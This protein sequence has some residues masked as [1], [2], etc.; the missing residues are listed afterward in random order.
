MNVLCEWAVSIQRTG[1][2]RALVVAKLL[3]R[4]QVEVS[5]RMPP[6]IDQS[7]KSVAGLFHTHLNAQDMCILIFDVLLRAVA[8]A[9]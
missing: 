5:Q 6:M 2:Y 3:E 1:E 9:C 8:E 7:A 4:R